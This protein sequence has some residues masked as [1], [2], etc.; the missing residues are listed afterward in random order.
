MNSTI[1]NIVAWSA[2]TPGIRTARDWCQWTEGA[3][4]TQAEQLAVV[5]DLPAMLRRRLSSLGKVALSVAL[6]LLAGRSEIPCVFSSCHGELDKTVGLLTSLAEQQPLSPTHFSLSVHNAIGGVMSIARKDTS[7]ITAMATVNGDVSIALLEAAA[8]LQEQGCDEVLC[9]VYDEPVPALYANSELGP[10]L[11]Y[12]VAFLLKAAP[13]VKGANTDGVDEISS[14]GAG[15]FELQVCPSSAARDAR[16]DDTRDNNSKANE[17]QALAL[18][19]YILATSA[20]PLLLPAT[21]HSWSWRRV[22]AQGENDC[23]Q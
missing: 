1:I 19:R 6:P 7:A 15:S 10:E 8:I 5:V 3:R 21:R 16:V 20:A 4:L 14:L 17:P 11:P 22:N 18:L 9:V 23:P 2:W 12:A 13:C